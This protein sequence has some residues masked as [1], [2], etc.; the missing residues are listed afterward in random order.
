LS[1]NSQ[2]KM[3][4][5]TSNVTYFP[6][7]V[8]YSRFGSAPYVE[9]IYLSFL[10]VGII[11]LFLNTLSF[12]VL[13]SK[14]FEHAYYKYLR[15]YIINSLLLC[16]AI[17]SRFA[18]V[19]RSIFSFSNTYN[20]NWYV[21]NISIP[22]INVCYHYGCFLDIILAFERVVLLSNKFTWFRRIKPA[23][24][25]VFFLILS[26]LID[27]IFY[28]S[29]DIVK[30]KINLNKTEIFIMHLFTTRADVKS[31]K[32]VIA[33]VSD[34]IPMLMEIFL[35]AYGIILMKSFVKKKKRIMVANAT[36]L[37]ERTL[38]NTNNSATL[39]TNESVEKAKRME[40]KLAI[41]TVILVL[42]S[43]L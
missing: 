24:L 34:I 33:Y 40:V 17:G 1:D 42:F 18:S 22:L 9:G 32:D 12:I 5:S 35:G 43:I 3:S 13:Q 37:T 10:S 27:F 4:N 41:M 28:F 6:L 15:V 29:F 7:S 31:L 14:E 38:A 21:V 23:A 11:G 20:A 26:I 8:W 36:R 2:Q 25:C 30:R 16:F 19:T 39:I